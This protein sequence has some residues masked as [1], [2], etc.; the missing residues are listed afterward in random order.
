MG[1]AF[2]Q[3]AVDDGPD[4]LEVAE[5]ISVPEAEHAISFRFDDRGSGSIQVRGVLAAIHFDYELRPVTREIGNE[6]SDRHLAPEKL[7]GTGF[8]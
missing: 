6:V 2:A 7:L 8:A 5:H 3:Y 1:V 4:T